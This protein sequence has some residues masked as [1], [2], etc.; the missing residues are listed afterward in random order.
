MPTHTTN[1]ADKW[2]YTDLKEKHAD[3]LSKFLKV[4]ES[5][6]P[7][8]TGNNTNTSVQEAMKTEQQS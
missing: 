7:R 3:R 4:T 6:S 5:K 1:P 8:K 2:K